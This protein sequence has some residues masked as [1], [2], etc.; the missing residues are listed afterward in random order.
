M[1]VEPLRPG[2]PG[3]RRAARRR[4][5]H[6]RGRR[7]DLIP[8]HLPGYRTRREVFDDLVA[9]SG[10]TLAERFPRR[11]AHLRVLV[12]EVPPTDPA[13]WEDAAVLLGRALPATREHP[14]RA[15]LYRR[16]IQTRCASEEDLE[17]LVRQVLS[18]QVGSLLGIAP[19]DVD[20]GAWED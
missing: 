10:A 15:I 20:P 3:P 4:D 8:P 5:R 1:D 9:E 19:E 11:L 6:G 16:P 17:A 12:E 13:P 7:F 14:P 2:A 18:E